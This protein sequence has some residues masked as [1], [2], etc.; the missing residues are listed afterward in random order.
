MVALCSVKVSV[1]RPDEKKAASSIKDDLPIQITT[2]H[3]TKESLLISGEADYKDRLK[4]SDRFME[5]FVPTE[6]TSDYH[7]GLGL[8]G[9]SSRWGHQLNFLFGF[10]VKNTG[11]PGRSIQSFRVV[12]G[13]CLF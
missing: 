7:F 12:Q 11:L 1:T 2:I 6:F 9:P 5:G 13:A 10:I 8:K 4:K 3:H